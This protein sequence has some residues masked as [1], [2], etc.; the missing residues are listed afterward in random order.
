MPPA[1]APREAKTLYQF[2]ALQQAAMGPLL[3]MMQGTLGFGAGPWKAF[4]DSGYGQAMRAAND[5]FQLSFRRDRKPR[6][7][8]DTTFVD[9]DEVAVIEVPVLRKIFCTLLH[10][11][12]D[13]RRQDPKVLVLAPMAGHFATHMRDTI[14][15]LLPS[16]EVYVTD[17]ADARDVPEADGRF[18][19]EDFVGCVI[20]FIRLLGPEVHVMAVC[21]SS[22][23]GLEAAALMAADGEEA[24]P[25]SLVLA[26]GPIDAR[27]NPTSI[28]QRATNHSL[29]WFEATMIDT[30]PPINRGAGRSVLPGFVQLSSLINVNFESL[31]E[32]NAA[33]FR[34][35]ASGNRDA[36]DALLRFYDEYLSV[37]DLTAEFFLQTVKT[38]FQDF[39]LPLGNLTVGGRRVEPEAIGDIALMTVEGEADE[40]A[41]LGQTR[42]AHDLC[43]NVPSAKRNHRQFAGLDHLGLI[44]GDRWRNEIV[45]EVTSFI[46][47]N[48]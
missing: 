7:G 33:L 19:F 46:R 29:R 25:R 35:I 17:W 36:A 47:A 21:Q 38:V 24:R 45:P 6:F 12:R 41:G 43:A 10:F 16:H 23:P 18:D 31:S 39:D 27:I 37:M 15:G 1:N 4:S 42:A 22:V 30:V 11:R 3:Q 2:Y 14:A 26:G 40:I 32:K 34:H 44:V 8:L 13:V 28:D 20:E 5:L 9:G 48:A